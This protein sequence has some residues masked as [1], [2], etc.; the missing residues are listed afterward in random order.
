MKIK[1][2]LYKAE[3]F[4]RLNV[5]ISKTTGPIYTIYYLLPIYL[6]VMLI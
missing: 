3:E 6:P 4:L 1:I 5:Q 2:L